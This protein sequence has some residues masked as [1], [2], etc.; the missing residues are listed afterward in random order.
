MT[1][2][3]L[4]SHVITSSARILLHEFQALAGLDIRSLLLA[5][6]SS[7]SSEPSSTSRPEFSEAFAVF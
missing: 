7:K 5:T 4:V 1:F 2:L 3:F 6:R